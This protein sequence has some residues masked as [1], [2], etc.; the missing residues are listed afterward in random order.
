V[1]DDNDDDDANEDEGGGKLAGKKRGKPSPS[2]NSSSSVAKDTSKTNDDSSHNNKNKK[3]KL[4]DTE[5]DEGEGED[6]DEDE[7]PLTKG[8]RIEGD[9]QDEGYWYDGVIAKV[10]KQPDGTYKYDVQ[11]DDGDFEENMIRNNIRVLVTKVEPSSLK[12]EEEEEEEEDEDGLDDELEDEDEDENDNDE[13]EGEKARIDK[14]KKVKYE[15]KCKGDPYIGKRIARSYRIDEDGDGEN[16]VKQIFFGTVTAKVTSTVSGRWWYQITFDDGDVD[17]LIIPHLLKLL[18]FYRVKQ[19]ED[20]D[21]MDVDDHD[22][23]D[24]DEG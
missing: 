3:T 20:A 13:D 16:F 1:G 4:S 17:E 15:K 8:T 12:E 6:E 9:F 18:H 19:D 7:E 11:Y 24:G 14:S 5:D 22:V 23:D 21:T 2:S 10:R